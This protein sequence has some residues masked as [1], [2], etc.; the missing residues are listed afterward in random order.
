MPNQITSTILMVRPANFGF[1]PETA[2]NNTFQKNDPSL[3]INT[4]KEKAIQEFD[5]FVEQ[6]IAHGIQVTVI[7]DTATPIKTDAVF[8]NNWISFHEDGLLITYP[9]FSKNRRLER[10]P[11]IIETFSKSYSIKNHIRLEKWESTLQ[12]LEGTG[13]IIIDRVHK[14][15]YAS[16]SIR[17][18]EKLFEDYCQFMKYKKVVFQSVDADGIPIYHTNVMMTLG[19][20]FVII[21]MESIPDPIEKEQLR[22]LFTATNK[23]VIDI[24]LDQMAHFAG[25][26][27]QVKNTEG[28]SYLVMSSQAFHS[29]RKDQIQEIESYT[30]ILHSDLR[31]I[32]T[33]GG[34]SARCM[35]AEVFC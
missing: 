34:G 4:I 9:M 14:I 3:T 24:T 5:A 7:P 35:I 1:N 21:C 16:L 23:K 30:N 8:P 32:E 17:T 13:S 33:Y 22:S 10:R 31:T 2:D 19:T 12:Y 18:D 25:N 11:D 27:L 20:D 28:L 6:L 26:M 15:A 29:L